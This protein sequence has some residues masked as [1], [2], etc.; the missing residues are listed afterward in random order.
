MRKCTQR[1]IQIRA[2]LLVCLSISKPKDC[3][4][5]QVYQQQSLMSLIG[6]VNQLPGKCKI[7]GRN[8]M[9]NFTRCLVIHLCQHPSQEDCPTPRLLARNSPNH[10]TNN[11]VN[12][13]L[14]QQS[15]RLSNRAKQKMQSKKFYRGQFT[16]N[17]ATYLQRQHRQQLTRSRDRIARRVYRRKSSRGE[18][19]NNQVTYYQ[20]EYPTRSFNR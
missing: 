6:A 16:T 15:K 12:R 20:R 8:T 13:Q 3:L 7:I 2:E 9:T 10:I 18:Y 14:Q 19:T 4:R 5:N 11:R 1:L 17:R